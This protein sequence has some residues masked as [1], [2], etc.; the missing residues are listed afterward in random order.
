MES[1]KRPVA[2]SKIV[3]VLKWRRGHQGLNFSQDLPRELEPFRKYTTQVKYISLT[4]CFQLRCQ[5]SVRCSVATNT[6]AKWTT[7]LR[8]PHDPLS[9]V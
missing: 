4:D 2:Y 1:N 3:V 8:V 9:K 6:S 5:P 7:N